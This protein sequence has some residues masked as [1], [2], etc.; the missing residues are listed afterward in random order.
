[1]SDFDSYDCAECGEQFAAHPSSL[2]ADT[3]Y[4]SPS[5]ESDGKGLA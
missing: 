5:C 1:M 3:S 4:C 2:A